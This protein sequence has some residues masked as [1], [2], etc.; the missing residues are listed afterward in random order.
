VGC[1]GAHSKVFVYMQPIISSNA[2]A[3]DW[4][5]GGEPSRITTTTNKT[6]VVAPVSTASSMSRR[7]SLHSTGKRGRQRNILQAGER[8]VTSWFPCR[9]S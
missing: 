2:T 1:E 7:S 6:E 9:D 8:G 4:L 5:R 3:I